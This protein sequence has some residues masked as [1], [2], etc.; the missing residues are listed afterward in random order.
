MAIKHTDQ[1]WRWIK[2]QIP[3]ETHKDLKAR[4]V[5]EDTTL[6]A[7]VLEALQASLKKKR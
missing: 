3:A 5:D 6:Q 7:L 4:A 2:I 1:P